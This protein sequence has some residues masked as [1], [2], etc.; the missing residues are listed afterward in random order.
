[1]F[2]NTYLLESTQYISAAEKE[3]NENVEAEAYLFSGE[4][5]WH[6]SE[7]LNPSELPLQKID[8]SHEY[9]LEEYVQSFAPST[10][11][12]APEPAPLEPVIGV[13]EHD[14]KWFDEQISHIPNALHNLAKQK[15][16]AVATS[17]ST[18]GERR[19]LSNAWLRETVDQIKEHP[20]SGTTHAYELAK[21]VVH[22]TYRAPAN[23]LAGF[24]PWVLQRSSADHM[25]IRDIARAMTSVSKK[26][27]SDRLGN[28][29]DPFFRED[30]PIE[31]SERNLRRQI[32]KAFRQANE[33]A[34]LCLRKVGARGENYVSNLTLSHRKHQLATQ[35]AWIAQT[36]CKSD[37]KTIPLLQC[38]RSP[39]E[40][41]CEMYALVQGLD[42]YYTEKGYISVMVT[43]TLPS[44]F[45]PNPSHG[46][47]R[48]DGSSPH[49][50]HALFTENW[51]LCR[52]SI[53]DAQIDIHGLRVTEVH[54][55]GCPHY[56]VLF[57]V[58][59]S[60]YDRFVKIINEYFAHSTS[61]VDF[62]LI[63]RSKSS[64]AG[65]VLKY[66]MKNV[67]GTSAGDLI[68]QDS[69]DRADAFRSTW[70][71][72]AFQFFGILHGRVT[73]W[74]ELRRLETQPDDEEHL[75][76]S[77]WRA[78][79]GTKADLFI[80]LLDHRDKKDEIKT[81]REPIVTGE[82]TEPDEDGSVKPIVKPGRV[83]GIQINQ[84]DYITHRTSWT[85]IS[86][87]ESKTLLRTDDSEQNLEDS[88]LVRRGPREPKTDPTIIP[89]SIEYDEIL[90]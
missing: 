70:G 42:K 56:H 9:W 54:N 84:I 79:R 59:P 89:K 48:W 15:Y 77:L 80:A 45:H 61:A 40:K 41:F 20:L 50:A 64:A 23:A 27:V 29:A 82:W 21:Q 90:S 46:T 75:A 6:L 88:T 66:I 53:S 52:T 47:N 3:F 34:A 68:E 12:P 35:S 78:A 55:D 38:I 31:I 36:Y 62:E 1:M 32:R 10:P 33:T 26:T 86:L 76:K 63:D 72:R 60:K 81:I 30:K 28:Y 24:T 85:L 13:H 8:Y 4:M 43:I 2:N 44:R 11:I 39:Y 87:L 73:L 25:T 49:A 69:V 14:L 7:L 71:I 74:R 22:N 17:G 58:E 16:F 57:F 37:S 65:Y 19:R 67:S 51:A 18:D 5:E 83:L